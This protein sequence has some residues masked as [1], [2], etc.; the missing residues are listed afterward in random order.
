MGL[1]QGFLGAGIGNYIGTVWNSPDNDAT[2]SFAKVF[3]QQF[4]SGYTV[5]QAILAARNF[6]A[7]AY[8]EEDLTWAR[9][10]L[11]GDPFTHIPINQ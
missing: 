10:V 7:T 6:C 5:S 11:F 8:G 4:L 9:Y 1:A 3:Y 2:I